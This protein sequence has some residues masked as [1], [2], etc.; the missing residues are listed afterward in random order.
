MKRLRARVFRVDSRLS[1]R[2]STQ[3][4]ET[5]CTA[6]KSGRSNL[7]LL[8]SAAVEVTRAGKR[9]CLP[10]A[11]R[12]GRR[13]AIDKSFG[14]ERDFTRNFPQIKGTCGGTER[15]NGHRGRFC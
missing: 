10:E 5:Y 14:I 12:V 11:H 4:S 15:D 2:Q 8:G 9:H 7:T 13:A 1:P 3:I 6:P